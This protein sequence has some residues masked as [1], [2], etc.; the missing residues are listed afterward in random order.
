MVM[1]DILDKAEVDAWLKANSRTAKI[2][3]VLDVAEL[4]EFQSSEA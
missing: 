1:G 2:T 3:A 4:A